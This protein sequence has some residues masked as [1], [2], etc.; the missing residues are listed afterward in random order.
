MTTD[1]SSRRAQ[2]MPTGVFALMDAAKSEAR[3]RGLEVID[4]S[5]GSSD[6]PP[7]ES[8]LEAL[9]QATYDPATYAYCLHSGTRELREAAAGWHQERFGQTLDP[10]REIL[11]LIGSQ[12]GFAH[13]LLAAADPGDLILL[14]DP[15]YPS[16]YG[17][18]ALAG[19]E[20]KRMPLLEE[21][22]YLPDLTAIAPEIARRARIMVLSY[23]NNPTTAVA[24][25]EFF[26]QAVRFCLEHRILLVHDFP[27]VDMVYGDYQAPS[28]LSVPGALDT[29]VEL[30]S[31][32]KSHHMGGFRIGW[33]AG[34]AGVIGP[35]AA[36]KG[37]IDFNAYL[38]IQRAAVAAL[39]RSRSEVRA[40]VARL[41]A[42][43]DAL[44]AALQAR[45]W[46]AS[47]PLGGMYVWARLPRPWTDSFA[48]AL[49]LARQTGVALN[50]GRAFG[51]HGEGY[52][53]FALVREPEVL[54]EAVRRVAAFCVQN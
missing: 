8:A 30:Y 31:L 33:A 13:L 20:V 18:V 34:G 41:E 37:A 16:Y 52:V 48:F 22:G 11:P 44:L 1:W 17:A 27:Y 51:E 19:L 32:S 39:Q 38:G 43:R 50:P 5:I 47:T 6:L 46:Q 23:P 24:P 45:G 12:E 3:A 53:R 26:E 36:V 25:P 10:E 9:R 42:R 15:G 7:P 21:H 28:V 29:A 40:D 2:A 4:L 54:E 35:L 49:A 14:P